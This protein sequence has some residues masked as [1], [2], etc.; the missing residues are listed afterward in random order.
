MHLAAPILSMLSPP[1]F[2]RGWRIALT[3][4]GLGLLMSGCA[5]RPLPAHLPLPDT[6]KGG[7][8][9]GLLVDMRTLRIVTFEAMITDAIQAQLITIGEEHYH[10]DIQA[11]E[12]KT[13]NAIA[14]K[15]P[16]QTALAMEFLER[17]AQ[18]A[19]D[20]YLA[21]EIDP[22]ALHQRLKASA[23]FQKGYTPLIEAA[24][25]AQ[26]PTLA[27][28]L[29]RRIA[30]QIARK[31]LKLTQDELDPT[32]Q[33]YWPN[34][35]PAIPERYRTYF[36]D[37]VSQHH[38]VKGEQAQHFTEASFL[39]DVT[40]AATLADFLTEHPHTT[41]L[42]I[43]GRFHVDY[44]IAIPALFEHHQPQARIRRITTRSIP[45]RERLDLRQ[46]QQDGVADYI[47]FFPP[48]P[49]APPSQ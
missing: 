17:D 31:G 6:A 37:Q 34:P 9:H 22:D 42:A 20:A 45:A 38:Q 12:R 41:I 49:S 7:Q 44:G 26:L 14:Q 47:H 23:A 28:N 29:P 43:A 5:L 13:L 18:P 36:L 48:R 24:R 4:I 2:R 11:F 16:R 33:A 1:G 19:V 39:K 32:D 10:P 40:M 15:R 35:I 3:L 27:M 30:R 8:L 25:Q 21:G 46:L